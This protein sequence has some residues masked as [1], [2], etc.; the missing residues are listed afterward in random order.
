MRRKMPTRIYAFPQA[1][2]TRVV[3]NVESCFIILPGTYSREVPGALSYN[4]EIH[5]AYS[6][7]GIQSMIE[8]IEWGGVS[9]WGGVRTSLPSS[10][11]RP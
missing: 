1:K 4:S 3:I 5:T 6:A 9:K 11:S 7:Q 10:C 2:R 8:R